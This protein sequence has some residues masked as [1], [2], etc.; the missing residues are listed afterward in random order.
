MNTLVTLLRIRARRDRWQFVIWVGAFAL[1]LA[2]T[3]AAMNA[4]YGTQASREAV[5][6]FA[7]GDPALLVVRGAPQGTSLGAM[8]AFEIMAFTG[9]LMGLMNTFLAVRHTRADEEYGRAELVA[10]TSAGRELPT[11]ATTLW[12]VI[13]NVAVALVI[14]LA[15]VV[16][17][18]EMRG[19]LVFASAMGA[20]G[21]TFLGVGLLTS[22]V[23]STSRAANG[24]AAGLVGLAYILRGVGDATG[25]RA[26]DGIIVTSGW[27]SWLSPIG[28]AQQTSPYGLNQWWPMLLCIVA[29]AVLVAVTL[30]LQSVRDSGAGLV[31]AR[32]GRSTAS[33]ALRGPLGLAWRLQRASVIGWALGA[34]ALALL[35]G[36]LGPT[37]IST[38]TEDPQLSQAVRSLVPGGTG[39]LM[40][41]FIAAMMGI[42]GLTV[43]GCVLQV[44][45]RLR[46]EEAWG[47]AEAVLAT[48]VGRMSWFSGFLV[49][50]LIAAVLILLLCGLLTGTMLAAAG[51][52]ETLFG[53]SVAA[54]AAQLPAVLVY[55]TVLGLVFALAP[56]ATVGVGWAM[57]AVGAFLGE[58]GGLLKLPEWAR[59]I[60]P[61]THTP[62]VPLPNA[63][64]SGAWWMLAVAVAAA[65]TAFVAVRRRDLATG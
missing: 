50:G 46:Q 39:G 48:R 23:F 20:T 43:A 33:P 9:L 53:K 34:L 14:F 17:G 27:A 52:D 15:L 25:T 40:E 38:V 29:G 65:I 35:A 64:W 31:A 56:R 41:V 32:A 37:S 22:Q 55:L 8:V 63:D 45:M 44:V 59:N 54:A 49:V 24:S 2:F 26:D 10:A 57:L 13:L 51:G 12:G 19:S 47:T 18:L 28:W 16:G 21:I 30:A 58:F 42:V 4:T 3:A 62:T 11:L 1:L 7:A 6:R 5:L 36:S 60:S 61:F